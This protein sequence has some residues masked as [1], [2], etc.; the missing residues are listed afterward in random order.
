MKKIL[1]PTDFSPTANK[2][3]DFAIQVA[4]KSGGEVVVIHATD[5]NTTEEEM[6]RSNE[7]LELIK[8]SVNQ[9]EPVRITTVLYDRSLY[10][11]IEDAV[12]QYGIDLVIM[13]TVGNTAFR[14]KIFG[15][16]TAGVIGRSPVPVLA[17][18]L[19]SEWTTPRTMVVAINNF[20]MDHAV[21]KPV[22]ALAQTFATSVQVTIFTDL[23]DDAVEDFHE[24]EINIANFRDHLKSIY[25]QIE[26]HA[27]HL[28]GRHFMESLQHWIDTNQV[29][30]LVMLTHRRSLLGSVFNR[31]MT[32][33][34][35]YHTNVPLLA[36]PA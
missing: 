27:V 25:T 19:L 31:S 23:D 33:K 1:V 11:A 12:A 8:K 7:Q 28:A 29:D 16:K 26:I 6:L 9:T 30:W 10:S 15:S 22:L 5:T 32:R 35:A 4:R 2:A 3:L 17:V 21:L 13:G 14:E 18:P 24:H 36:I 20:D 34:M